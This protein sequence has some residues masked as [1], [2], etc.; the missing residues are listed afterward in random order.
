MRR[1]LCLAFGL[2]MLASGPAWAQATAEGAA[3][4]QAALEA[5]QPSVGRLSLDEVDAVTRMTMIPFSVSDWQVT[6]DGDGYR[7]A[8]PGFRWLLSGELEEHQDPTVLSCDAESV[9]AVPTSAGTFILGSDRLL[10]CRVGNIGRIVAKSRRVTGTV[11]P[12]APANTTIVVTFEQVSIE[13]GT[14]RVPTIDRLELTRSAKA[15][16]DGRVDLDADITI[17]GLAYPFP[18]GVGE[19][20]IDRILFDCGMPGTDAAGLTRSAVALMKAERRKTDA[21][22]D[23]IGPLRDRVIAGLG[24]VGT[25]T[26]T[27]A[28]L[29]AKRNEVSIGLSSLAVGFGYRDFDRDGAGITLRLDMKDL[30]VGPRWRYA[31]WTPTDSIMQ[32]SIEGFPFWEIFDAFLADRPADSQEDQELFRRARMRLSVDAMQLSAPDAALEFGGSV[33]R[34]PDAVNGWAG[35]LRL[36]LTGIDGLVKAL[37]ADPK[38][39]QAAAGLTMV[40]VLGRQTTLPDG[41]TARDYEIVIDP[42][43]KVLVNGADVQALVPKDL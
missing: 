16:A 21:A 13:G 5:W 25:T 7:V 35:A 8:V 41:R 14:T 17:E 30:S 3:R 31:A 29:Q 10:A 2:G 40:Q 37:Q 23:T 11:D 18:D 24:K 26:L 32:V 15:V 43:G 22:P 4:L 9:R 28:G 1:S 39:S 36:R 19:L 6:A 38:A 20:R 33:A 34:V 12:G 27:A 42:S